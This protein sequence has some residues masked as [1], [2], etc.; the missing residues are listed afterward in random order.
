M[1]IGDLL[2][3]EKMDDGEIKGYCEECVE[4]KSLVI[5]CMCN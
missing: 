5:G 4:K 2:K 1:E 3:S